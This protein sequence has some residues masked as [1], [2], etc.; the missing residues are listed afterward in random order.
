[1]RLL[2]RRVDWRPLVVGLLSLGGVHPLLAGE[3]PRSTDGLLHLYRLVELDRLLRSGQLYPRWA[4]DLVQGYGAPLFNFYPPLVY[5]IAE[6]LH[7]VG[8]SLV[9]ALLATLGLGLVV[10]GVAMYLLVCDL[11][12]ATAGLLAAMAY[13]YAPYLLFNVYQRGNPAEA[14]GLA[15]VPLTL[16]A[17]NRLMVRRSRGAWVLSVLSLASVILLHTPTALATVVILLAFLCLRW[18][19]DRSPRAASKAPP[20]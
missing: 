18:A 20:A 5:Y 7:R 12:D 16:W 11:M 2:L 4:P 17:F 6:G 3:M 19:V 13:T 14:W 10:S 1:M 8:L 15:G 9:P